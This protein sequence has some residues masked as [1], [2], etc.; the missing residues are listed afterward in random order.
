MDEADVDGADV[1]GA[2]D[3]DGG[4]VTSTSGEGEQDIVN[5]KFDWFNQIDSG[6]NLER[7]TKTA[8]FCFFETG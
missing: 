2:D 1:D 5:C 4:G 7:N 3:G 6:L 8:L